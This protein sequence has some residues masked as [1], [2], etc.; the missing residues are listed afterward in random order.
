VGLGYQ[1]KAAEVAV[2]E[3]KSENKEATKEALLRLAL[4]KIGRR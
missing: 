3:A 2:S 4:Q 1:T